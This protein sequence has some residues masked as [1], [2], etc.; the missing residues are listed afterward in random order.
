MLTRF[1]STLFFPPLISRRR[2]RPVKAAMRRAPRT[3]IINLVVSER[4][5]EKERDDF[6]TMCVTVELF[7]VNSA[8]PTTVTSFLFDCYCQYKR[9]LKRD[10]WI[11]NSPLLLAPQR[12]NVSKMGL[13]FLIETC[14]F[15]DKNMS[16]LYWSS[17]LRSRF[18]IKLANWTICF[19]PWTGTGRASFV[20]SSFS[21]FPRP[22]EGEMSVGGGWLTRR[23]IAAAPMLGDARPRPA[24]PLINPC[25]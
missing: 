2:V 18:L 8:A 6:C 20:F 21:H 19:R 5:Q 16:D 15:I 13:E 14:D 4:N 3:Y 12:R 22:A 11:N 17:W 1:S 24:N 10:E 23:R 25:S 9:A 7:C